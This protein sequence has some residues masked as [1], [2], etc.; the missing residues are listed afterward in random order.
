MNNLCVVR[1]VSAIE[2]RFEIN[3][4]VVSSVFFV[5]Y[6]LL[7][8]RIRIHLMISNL[9]QKYVVVCIRSKNCVFIRVQCLAI[10]VSINDLV[11][12]F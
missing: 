12:S 5:G 4:N 9:E 6:S 8:Q 1:K 7:S 2:I 3:L 10:G 11:F